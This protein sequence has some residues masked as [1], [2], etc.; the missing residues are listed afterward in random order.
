MNRCRLRIGA[1]DPKLSALTTP[2]RMELLRKGGSDPGLITTFF[3]MGRHMLVVPPSPGSLPPNLQGLWEPGLK[4]AWNGDFH[5]NINVQMNLWPANPT[6]LGECNKP[7]R[8]ARHAAQIRPRNRRQ[9]RLRR[10]RSRTRQRR[11]GPVRLAGRFARVGFVHPRRPLGAAA[12]DGVLS[13]HAGPRVPRKDD[14]AHPA[15]RLALP[16][17]LAPPEPETGLLIAGPGGSPENKFIFKG[18]DGKDRSAYISIGNAGDQSIAWETFSDTLECAALLRRER[19]SHRARRRGHQ[20]APAPADRR[21][22][23]HSRMVEALRRGVEGPPAQEPSIRPAS[24]ASDHARARPNWRRPR[25]LPFMSAWT[26]RT[27]TAPVAATPA[28]ISPGP[29]TWARLQK[30]DL[31]LDAIHEQLRTQV[32]ENLFNRCGGPFQIDGN[33][34]TPAA[35]AEMLVQ[36][37][38]IPDKE[39]HISNLKFEIDSSPPCPPPGPKVP[40]RACEL[41]V[42]ASWTSNGATAAWSTTASRGP[43]A[44]PSAC[45]STA[46]GGPSN[47]SPL[48]CRNSP[49][50]TYNN[51]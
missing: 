50:R 51:P 23:P 26:R 22:R 41:A 24:R 45:A 11:V 33:L 10:L 1:D 34:G 21:G 36:S 49:A 16:A 7:F 18:A 46:S 28:G 6:G 29:P 37:R 19:R 25:R 27:E 14:V 35:I 30:G 13:L 4:A 32:N 38:Q 43:P 42:D 44:P 17:R 48:A 8:A 9:P 47:L 15:R 20:A 39:S 31:A 12:P 40:Y 2:E 3:Q 5:L